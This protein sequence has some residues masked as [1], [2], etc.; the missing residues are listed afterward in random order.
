[1][2]TGLEGLAD[3][4]RGIALGHVRLVDL[5][6]PPLPDLG[7]ELGVV[8]EKGPALP[9]LGLGGTDVR[10]CGAQERVVLLREPLSLL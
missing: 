5:A 9:Q 2:P 8:P 7:A 4:D 10:A 1:M 3:A 6:E